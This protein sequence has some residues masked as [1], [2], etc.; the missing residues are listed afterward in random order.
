MERLTYVTENGEILFHP[1]DLPE[2]E[3]MTIRQLAEDERWKALNQIA[4]KL[5]NMEQME[6]QGMLVRLPRKVGGTVY[7]LSYRYDCKNNYD[8]KA[9][10]KW[11]CEENIPC[12]YEKKEYFVKKSQFCLTMLNSLGKTVFLT[13]EE[14]EKALEEMGK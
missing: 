2:D 4:E 14:A 5:T 7:T 8:C 6:E 10:Q 12:E 1:E 13:R 3:G 11:K 9:F